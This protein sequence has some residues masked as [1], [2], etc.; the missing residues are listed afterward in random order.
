MRA[1]INYLKEVRVELSKVIWPKRQE[2]TKL[3][4]IVVVISLIVS[5]YVGILDYLFVQ[6]IEKLI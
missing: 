3:S 1:A 4:L 5:A 2:V 6:V